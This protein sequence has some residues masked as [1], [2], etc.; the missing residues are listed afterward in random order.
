MAAD[1]GNLQAVDESA[2]REPSVWLQL[3]QN[4]V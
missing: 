1:A 3:V 2:A 4:R